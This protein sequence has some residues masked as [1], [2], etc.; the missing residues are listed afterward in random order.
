MLNFIYV[1]IFFT[2]K[3]LPDLLSKYLIIENNRGISEFFE[4][5][6]FDSKLVVMNLGSSFIFLFIKICIIAIFVVI[7]FLGKSINW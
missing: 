4:E 7:H 1:D 2:E 3:W 5:N 6:G